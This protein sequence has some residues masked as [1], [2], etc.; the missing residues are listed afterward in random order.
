MAVASYF[1]SLS[2]LLHLQDTCQGFWAASLPRQAFPG[3]G[4]IS[5]VCPGQCVR[6]G[7]LCATLV[8]PIL[9]ASAE[10]TSPCQCF[11]PSPQRQENN[12]HNSSQLTK[13]FFQTIFI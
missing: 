13:V 5:H 2:P 1:S 4:L 11:R 9:P 12:S 8:P 7:G 10:A 3:L 6:S